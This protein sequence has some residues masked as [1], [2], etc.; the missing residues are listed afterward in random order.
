M[1]RG[2][3]REALRS[4]RRVIRTLAATTTARP[5]LSV[6]LQRPISILSLVPTPIVLFAA[7]A[8]AGAFGKTI[9]APLDRVKILL[10]VR[11][12][13]QKGAVRE[14]ALRGGLLRALWAICQEEGILGFWKGNLPQVSTPCTKPKRE[15]PV[16]EC[17]A[18]PR[19]SLQRRAAWLVRDLQAIAAG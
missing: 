8:F 4:Q 19:G 1:G 2:R 18:S 5:P 16:M 14:A 6:L 11:G 3:S 12:G 10:Q 15:C 7:G 17:A 13:L 9:V